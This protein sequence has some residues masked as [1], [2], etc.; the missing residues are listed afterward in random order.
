MI[1]TLKDGKTEVDVDKL[2]DI[3]NQSK[4]KKINRTDSLK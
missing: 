3:M 1:L 2:I 4:S